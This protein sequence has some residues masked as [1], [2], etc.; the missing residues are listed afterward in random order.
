MEDKEKSRVTVHIM[1][2]EYILKGTSA[3]EKML[4]VGRYVDRLMR[5]LS[6]NNH[7]MSKQK[8][9]VLAA[10]NLADELLK[11]KE[12]KQGYTAGQPERRGNENELA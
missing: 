3:P 9:A 5:S 6:E 7:Q 10:L 8:I 1:G 11:L 12:E 2:E 4:N